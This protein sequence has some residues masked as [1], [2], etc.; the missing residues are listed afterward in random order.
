MPD[1]IVPPVVV[2]PVVTP[3]DTVVVKADA[4]KTVDE[5]KAE[6]EAAEAAYKA[7]R[8]GEEDELKANMIRRRDKANEKLVKVTTPANQ[9]SNDINARD[10]L[11]MD[12]AGIAEG[13]DEAKV[14]QK[15]VQSGIVKDYREALEHVGV[16]AELD[17]IRTK[18]TA[19]TVI[20]ESDNDDVR[21]GTEREIIS[22]YEANG[23]VPSD[24]KGQQAIARHNLK[25]MGL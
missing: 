11:A 2:P 3:T 15:Y 18:S 16:K 21:L 5:L 6:A 4:D 12:K 17:V 22:N 13:S 10:L 19:K 20:D 25:K 23:T 9:P 8:P 14:L 1:P 7:A 24:K